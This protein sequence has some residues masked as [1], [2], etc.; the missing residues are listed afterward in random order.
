[1]EFTKINRKSADILAALAT[2]PVFKK[3]GTVKARPAAEGEQIVTVL[4]SGH[5]E[6]TNAAKAG[7]W[8]VTNPNGEQYIIGS[9]KFNSRYEMTAENGVYAAR[10][11]CRAIRNPFGYPIEI[12]A[13]WGSPQTG[14][15]HCLIADTCNAAGE[16]SGEPYLIEAAAFAKTY[17]PV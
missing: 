2:A 1:M 8:I 3:Q 5:Q 16:L 14:D 6:T 13:N 10:G 4:A 9:E 7:D 17:A 11:F 12:M 15:D